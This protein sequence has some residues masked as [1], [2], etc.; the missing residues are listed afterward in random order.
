MALPPLELPPIEKGRPVAGRPFCVV[1]K[2]ETIV[3][4]WTV[5]RVAKVRRDACVGGAEDGL[6]DVERADFADELI[7]ARMTEEQAD[8]AQLVEQLIR[9]QQVNGSSPFVGS[10]LSITYNQ[11]IIAWCTSGVPLIFSCSFC[12]ASCATLGAVL[13]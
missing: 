12:I 7:A 6:G 5:C 8:V 3:R 10:I 13:M 2:A 9:N 11:W 4:L 1:E